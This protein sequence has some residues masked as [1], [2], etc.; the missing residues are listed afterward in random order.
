MSRHVLGPGHVRPHLRGNRGDTLTT[1]SGHQWCPLVDPPVP[2]VDPFA[3][4]VVR[5]AGDERV[6]FDIAECAGELR[7]PAFF[8]AM[9]A[10]ALRDADA[11][12]Y[13]PL[14]ASLPAFS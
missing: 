1:G 14:G 12:G 4:P 8:D 5:V 7:P 6:P 13:A 11:L 2:A 10:D 9:V 3:A